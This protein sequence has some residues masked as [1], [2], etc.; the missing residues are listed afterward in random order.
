PAGLYIPQYVLSSSVR[1]NMPRR[2]NG[3]FHGPDLI[4]PSATRYAQRHGKRQQFRERSA[5]SA[6]APFDFA[7][8]E[9]KQFD[10]FLSENLSKLTIGTDIRYA[11]VEFGTQGP[12]LYLHNNSY[13][14]TPSSIIQGDYKTV[15]LQGGHDFD[16]PTYPLAVS[17]NRLLAAM[18]EQQGLY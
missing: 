13:D 5:G 17:P 4:G 3:W 11:G 2:A 14:R 8:P 16:R 10:R 15:L 9:Q 1:K 7:A 6:T 12:K 18:V